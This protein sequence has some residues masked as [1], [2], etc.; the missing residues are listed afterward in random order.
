MAINDGTITDLADDVGDKSARTTRSMGDKASDILVEV[1][2]EAGI[3]AEKAGHGAKSAAKSGKDMAAD[4]M[5][6]LADAARQMAGKLDDG[7]LDSGN[8]KA[9]DYARRAAD[10]MERFSASLKQKEIEEIADDARNAVR[11]NPAVAVGAAAIIGF[12]LARFLKG[13]GGRDA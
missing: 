4:A 9:A 13:S 8:A 10:G 5:K 7:E 12:A 11:N 1:K 3:F 6:G 2:E